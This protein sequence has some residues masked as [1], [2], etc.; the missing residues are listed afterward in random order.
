MANATVNA[1]EESARP[2]ADP[3]RI[4]WDHLTGNTLLAA[5]L[6]AMALVFA[7]AA[8]LPQSPDGASDPV[9]FSRW[10]GETQTHFGSSFALLQQIGLF[11][12]ERGPLL[13]VLLASLALCLS[14]RLVESLQSAWRA[15]RSP[16]PPGL[17]P[18]ALTT[19]QPLGDVAAHL[20]KLRFRVAAE[21]EVVYADRFPVA[22]SGQ[23]A[24]YLGALL[25]IVGLAVSSATGWR[26]GN[27]TLGLGQMAPLG[28]GTPYSLR[29]DALDSNLT[30]QITLL[31]ESDAIAPGRLA[32]GQP[33][34]QGDLTVF[35]TGTG[36]A[37]RASATFTDGQL[38]RLQA[39]AASAPASELLFFLT[40]DEPDRYMA[41][42]EAGLVVRVSRGTDNLQLIHVQV[43]RSK[44]GHL[45]YEG[46]VPSE[47]QVNV[48]NASFSLRPEAFA[49]LAIARDTGLPVTLIGAVILA[50]GLVT[51]AFWPIRQLAATTDAGGTKL[52]GEADLVRALESKAMLVTRRR[53]WQEAFTSVGWKIGPAFLSGML[54]LL[55]ARSLMRNG[56][57]W[58]S[59]APSL[60]F[61]VAWLV[62]CAAMLVPQRAPRWAAL[63]LALALLL[64][65]ISRPD[66]LIGPGL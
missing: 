45:E 65:V 17:T 40:R 47:T 61:T 31:E 5:V 46:D 16:Q 7:L 2:R 42:P 20:R 24:I 30:G 27:V 34:R 10:R 50:L 51:A 36:L 22:D 32:V 56:T 37:I 8:W 12:L 25:I 18:F 4:A 43:Y 28:H 60:V 23:I 33:V 35:L 11:S 15:R 1:I 3:W 26:V 49:A 58:P 9:A 57:L 53:R 14:L 62:S 55:A 59:S 64:V 19:Q 63:A 54:S 39:S 6:L 38:L 44:T 21:G 13:R 48:D 66:L 52:L 41:A 29:L